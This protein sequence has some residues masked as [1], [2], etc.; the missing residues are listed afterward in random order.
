MTVV[1]LVKAIFSDAT[2]QSVYAMY[3]VAIVGSGPGGSAAAATLTRQGFQTLL[4]DKADF[5]RDK[6][7]GDA[8]T[9]RAVR[10]L[11]AMG[12]LSHFASAQRIVEA[13]VVAPNGAVETI[14]F[15]QVPGCPNYL[16]IVPRQILDDTLRAHA[17]ASGATFISP[18]RVRQIEQRGSCVEI[19]GERA[20]QPVSFKACVA[21]IATGA[22]TGLLIQVGI[23]KRRPPM[24]L[25]VR[26]Y[27]D[28]V[29]DLI[30]HQIQFR[31]D[32]VPLPG[33]AWM[34]PTSPTSANVG[35][36]TFAA[37]SA[38]RGRAD[39]LAPRADFE[40]WLQTPAMQRH[41]GQALRRGPIKGYPI[42]SDFLHA[43]TYGNRVLLV[44]EAAGLVNPLTG[45]GIDF[46]LETGCM[47]AE[48]L[49]GMF[50]TGDFS[51]QALAG[52][53]R[54]LRRRY[55][56]FFRFCIGFRHLAM[57][58]GH[59][60]NLLMRTIPQYPSAQ[61]WLISVMLGQ[62]LGQPSGATA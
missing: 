28:A 58:N 40:R 4:L 6:T 15:P 35:L 44:G 18:V 62:Y 2:K 32:R 27:F 9:P 26:A 45:D 7:C 13:A 38:W 53:D 33:Y 42:R 17:V 60:L 61:R 11:D 36:G 16:Q 54:Q 46:A 10:M 41:L 50:A 25:A 52:Y 59:A 39:A 56:A 51:R 30:P 19:S 29:A 37:N 8:L 5:P 1:R 21:I 22:S 3:D 43:P 57:M 23:L 31:F 20:G 48:Y 49:A 12:V 55:V 14:G 47:A 34:F 24:N